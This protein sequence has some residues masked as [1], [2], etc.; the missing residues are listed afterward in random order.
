MISF[1][2]SERF[3]HLSVEDR[4]QLEIFTKL[5]QFSADEV[6]H[7]AGAASGWVGIV[8]SG[9]LRLEVPGRGGQVSVAR[10]GP[11]DLYGELETFARLPAGAR[12]VAERDTLVR[13]CPKNPLKQELRANRALAVGLLFAYSRSMS[14]KIRQ[15]NEALAALRAGQPSV[16][17]PARHARGD[18]PP[19]LT[20]DEVGWLTMLGRR[21]VAA[22]GEVIVRE[23]DTTRSFYVVEDGQ[24]EVRRGD[25]AEALALARFGPGDLFGILSFLDGQPRSAS[26]VTV[27]GAAAF[28]C[29]EQGAVD[30]AL[31]VNFSVA[32]RFLG[33]LC[34]VL[35]RTFADTADGIARA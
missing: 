2:T 7:E 18:R 11:G 5:D 16:P 14:E 31:K 22:D 9:A 4:D 6:V 23:G 13:V 33:T 24:V 32:F 26:V 19:H 20:A 30:S 21:Q 34:T 15:A 12:L 8:C 10:L 3:A 28:T 27:D 29:I 17:P 35:G 1:S 25:G